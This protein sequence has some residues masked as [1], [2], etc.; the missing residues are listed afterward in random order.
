MDTSFYD[1]ELFDD[2]IEYDSSTFNKSEKAKLE[3]NG[4]AGGDYWQQIIEDY[5]EH[6]IDGYEAE[7]VFSNKYC[8]RLQ[9]SY[10]YVLNMPLRIKQGQRPKYRMVH[11]TNHNVGCLLMVDNMLNQWELLQDMQKKGQISFLKEDFDNQIITEECLEM[12]VEK[13][14]SQFKSWISLNESMARFFVQH[15]VICSSKDI[16][17][18]V[19]C[20]GKEGYLMIRRVPE[21]TPTGRNSTFMEDKGHQKVFIRCVQ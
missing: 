19:K 4:I 21:K 1:E 16:R 13:Y 3:L 10:D 8:E 7:K 11:A 14:Y 15:G 9:Q 18:I 5:K 17:N 12:R 6:K 2:L 20:K